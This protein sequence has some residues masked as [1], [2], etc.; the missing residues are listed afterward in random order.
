MVPYPFRFLIAVV[1]SCSAGADW[2]AIEQA[3]T[4][5]L[6]QSGTPGA[7]VVVVQDDATPLLKG[8]GKASIETGEPVTPET[9]FRLGSTTKMFTAAA[10]L[11]LREQGRVDLAA[12][13]S[14]Y[15]RG[16]DPKI[17]ALTLEQ[18][19]THTAGLGDRGSGYGR[20][21][22]SAL[23]ATIRGLT[24][25]MLELEP[26]AVYSYSSL[27]Y[28]IAGLVIESVYGKPFADAVKELVFAPAGMQRT[29]FRPLEAM[30]YPFAQ[31]HEGGPGK[32]VRLIRP[33]ADDAATWP[34]GSLFSTATDLSRFLTAF[35]NGGKL[36][37]KQ[38]LLPGVVRAMSEG[39][40]SIPG[41]TDRYGYGLVVSRDRGVLTLSH[42]GARIG[43]GSLIVMVPEKRVAVA[44]ITNR[45][46]S[47]L[48]PVLQK[49]LE[50]LV[51]FGPEEP[52]STTAVSLS[53]GELRRYEGTF[54]GG[55]TRVETRVE[56][57]KLMIVFEE[58][59]YE[60]K[61]SGNHRFTSEGPL[62][63]FVFVPGADGS[64]R[65]LHVDLRTLRRV[66]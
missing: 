40:A 19:L 55:K 63:D 1:C 57:G 65:Y 33:F 49:A 38:A 53:D 3:A 43:F 27:G 58:K 52:S 16:L 15:V 61:P 39:H 59:S 8:F 44:A 22:D 26:G 41:S 36:D 6:E 50:S 30:T 17:G 62:S 4:A 34:G 9:L 10:L 12:P 66:P 32:P 5:A 60:A 18:L 51:Q 42:G 24:A 54:A 31:Q 20:H 64:L 7:A 25:E 56:N 14:K 29:T 37:G 48:G 28:W 2:H 11:T 35:L 47:T 46:G 21:D 45:S 23:A 13:V